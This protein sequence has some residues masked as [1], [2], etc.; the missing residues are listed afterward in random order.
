MKSHPTGTHGVHEGDWEDVRKRGTW[1]PGKQ[2]SGDVR[3]MGTS[4]MA[5]ETE[6]AGLERPWK[7]NHSS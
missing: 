6:F 2:D 7:Q 4:S 3:D 1:V 5:G